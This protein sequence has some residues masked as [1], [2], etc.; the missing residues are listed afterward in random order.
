MPPKRERLETVFQGRI[1]DRTPALGG[2][3]ACPE[4]ICALAGATM[5]EYWADPEGISIRAYRVLHVDGLIGIFVP[6]SDADFRCVDVNS[7]LHADKGLSLQE[8]LEYVEGLPSAEATE[9]GFDLDFE[10][11]SFRQEL[12][13]MQARCGDI[14]WMPAQWSAG[15]KITWFGDLGYEAFFCIVGGY[16]EHARK[17][18]EVGGAQGYCR[19]RLIARAVTEGLYPHAVLLGEDICTQR[20]PMVSPAFM[21]RYY[22]PQLRR[23]LQPLLEVGCKP[24]WHC[25]GDV[26]HLLDMLLDCGVQGLQGFQPE[27][28]L[29]IERVVRYRTREGRPLL[30]FGPLAVTTELPRITPEQVRAR[31]RHAIEVCRGN[32]DLVLF[33][34]N[35][36]NPDVPL[37]NIVAMYD[38]AVR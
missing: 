22:A 31:V 15:A 27:C 13:A 9:A 21:E 19:S 12:L 35:T 20:G 34:A 11:A 2:W 16:P 3:I 33:T 24:V 26:R 7:Y 14:A 38:E 36:I 25:D 5:A 30:I 10:Y 32:A 28:G 1:P 29:A 4:H 6:K 8:T 18:M 17:L 37:E 23:G